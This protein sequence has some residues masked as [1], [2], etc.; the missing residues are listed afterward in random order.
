MRPL[1]ATA[2]LANPSET[3]HPCVLCA[4]PHGTPRTARDRTDTFG[5]SQIPSRQSHNEVMVVS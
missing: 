5:Y 3:G 4:H 2:A 1:A